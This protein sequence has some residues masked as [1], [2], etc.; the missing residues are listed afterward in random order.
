MNYTLRQVLDFRQRS[1]ITTKLDQHIQECDFFENKDNRALDRTS[2]LAL[3]SIVI[4]LA[5]I[6][7]IGQIKYFV[8]I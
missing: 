8:E 6:A 4:L 5:I 3:N 1:I 2:G 7:V